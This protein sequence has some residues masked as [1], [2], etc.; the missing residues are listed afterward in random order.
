MNA[1]APPRP[2][3]TVRPG[4]SGEAGTTNK[5]SPPSTK[6]SAAWP[7][8]TS[9][10][11][12]RTARMPTPRPQRRRG[13]RPHHPLRQSPRRRPFQRQRH[14]NRPRGPAPPRTR[15]TGPHPPAERPPVRTLAR[16]PPY[17]GRRRSR[18]GLHSV[19]SVQSARPRPPHEPL[20]GGPP[21]RCPRRPAHGFLKA[22]QFTPALLACMQRLHSLAHARGQSLAQRALVWVL[23]GPVIP[24]ALIGASPV[25]QT[26]DRLAALKN[27]RLIPIRDQVEPNRPKGRSLLA[28]DSTRA[29]PCPPAPPH[30]GNLRSKANGNQHR[31]NRRDRPDPRRSVG[32]ALSPR[33][34]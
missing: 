15:P 24:P 31:R 27:P 13:P 33:R 6:T 32:P 23:R 20:P 12:I 4:P 16:T 11:G 14:A 10:V 34:P 17:P 25:S 19:L 28:G 21:R 7:S 18:P 1:S 22:G 30:R 26:E 29:I 2:G 9:V 3:Y 5:S 8:T